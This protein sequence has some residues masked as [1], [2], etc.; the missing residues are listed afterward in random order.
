M[1]ASTVYPPLSPATVQIELGVDASSEKAELEF[2]SLPGLDLSAV[3][4]I[5]AVAELLV[6]LGPLL[7]PFVEGKA[8]GVIATT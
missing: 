3:G 6:T 5:A 4:H 8:Y 2:E 7:N 1:I